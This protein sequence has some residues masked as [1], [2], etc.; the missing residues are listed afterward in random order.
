MNEELIKELIKELT[1]SYGSG[2]SASGW[3]IS[4]EKNKELAELIVLRYFSKIKDEV[5]ELKT[6]LFIY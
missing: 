2:G 6:K 1:T 4:G 3:L 5:T